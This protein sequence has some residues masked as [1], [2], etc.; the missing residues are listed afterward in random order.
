MTEYARSGRIPFERID[1]ECDRCAKVYGVTCSA[2]LGVTGERKCFNTKKTCQAPGDF[3][4][5]GETFWVSFS[6]N[7]VSSIAA[8]YVIPSLV[9]VSVSPAKLNPAGGGSLSSLGVRSAITVTFQDH[10]HTDRIV[11]PY[12]T[13][14]KTGDAQADGVGYNPYDLGTFWGKFRA[15]NEYL[16]NRQI[17]YV[18]GYIVD[19][20]MVDTETQ[21]FYSTG[22]GGPDS[23]GKVVISGVDPLGLIRND[24]AQA[25]ARSKGSLFATISAGAGSLTLIPAGVGDAYYPASGLARID[26]ELVTYTRVGDTVTLTGRAQK[27]TTAAEHE[28]GALFQ[29]CL[30]YSSQLVSDIIY[31]LLTQW[32]GVPASIIPYSD[33]DDEVT[34]HAPR[35]YSGVI[36]EPTGVAT[37]VA[38]LTEQA[39]VYVWYD[40]RTNQ[41]KMRA[42]RPADT[43]TVYE[44]DDERH[45]IGDSFTPK[46]DY[47]KL[48][49]QVWV[50]FAQRNPTKAVDDLTN[51]AAAEVA[52]DA[53]AETDV[54][55]SSIR[56]IYSRWIP[57][58]G[59]AAALEIA[60]T[61]LRRYRQPLRMVTFSIDAKDRDVDLADF[62]EIRHRQIQDAI[63]NRAPMLS[64]VIERT[65]AVTGTTIQ[66]TVQ[67]APVAALQQADELVIIIAADLV[68]VNLREVYDSQV[69]GTPVSGDKIRFIVRPNVFIGGYACGVY[70]AGVE[71]ASDMVGRFERRGL[72]NGDISLVCV[73]KSSNAWRP[74]DMAVTQY[75]A[76]ISSVVKKYMPVLQRRGIGAGA[77]YNIGDS[78]QMGA[79]NADLLCDLRVVPT[80][81]SLQVGTWPAGVGVTL[82]IQPGAEI[83]GEGGAGSMQYGEP[84]PLFAPNFNSGGWAGQGVGVLNNLVRAWRTRG[85]RGGDGGDAIDATA[86]PL[87]I[88]NNG[89]IRA[90]AG[91]GSAALAFRDW[92]PEPTGGLLISRPR[93]GWFYCGGGGR[94]FY[95]GESVADGVESPKDRNTLGRRGSMTSRGVPQRGKITLGS[96]GVPRLAYVRGGRGGVGTDDGDA[97]SIVWADT[98]ND[99]WPGFYTPGG[100]AGRAVVGSAN[101]TWATRGVVKGNEV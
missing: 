44:F 62:V 45:L 77:F 78:Y 6:S 43:D 65:E 70:P 67:E 17:R 101:V 97:G 47:G 2:V 18:S 21:L 26:D 82:E 87:T 38:E 59:G 55:G 34:E 51:Y 58:A 24:K 71:D 80:V 74:A 40:G 53:E 5:T 52:L 9:N 3:E 32:A 42:V 72:Y 4:L 76:F 64:Q 79:G 83:S 20:A 88:I 90:G 61:I 8:E 95:G 96:G 33:W 94:G 16:I 73:Q 100:R 13:E 1:L 28:A 15:R 36:A 99:V 19:G 92:T 75:R 27:F 50:S 48:I 56:R 98:G 12:V 11:D 81:P 31:N 30:E 7:Q 89:R 41:I 23:D 22:F 66:L 68:N 91:G 46:D 39:G 84:A 60:Q 54:K 35:L 69:G 25:P 86:H 93:D 10:P 57:A 49:T 85:V 29:Q 14:R 63:G 37:L